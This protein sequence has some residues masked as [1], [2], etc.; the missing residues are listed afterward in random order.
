MI[1]VAAQN[2]RLHVAS[3]DHVVWHQ[4]KLLIVHPI[5]L[6]TDFGKFGDGPRGGIVPK[7]QM[8]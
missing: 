4:Q 6:A 2:G 5:M 8:Q 1:D 7:Q 3:A